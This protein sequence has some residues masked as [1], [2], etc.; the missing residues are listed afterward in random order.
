M[1]MISGRWYC[2]GG[3]NGTQRQSRDDSLTLTVTGHSQ[4]TGQF[5]SWPPRSCSVVSENKRN[6]TKR[7]KRKRNPTII[8]VR[9]L[10]RTEF[11]PSNCLGRRRRI[12]DIISVPL[13]RPVTVPGTWYTSRYQTHRSKHNSYYCGP[14]KKKKRRRGAILLTIYH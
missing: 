2:F 5:N 1:M 9:L 12:S 4:F 11:A 13:E 3:V 10:L 6:E 14:P 8:F 7:K